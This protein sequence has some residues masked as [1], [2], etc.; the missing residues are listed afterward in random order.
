ME[1]VLKELGNLQKSPDKDA[2][3]DL[4]VA[5]RRCRSVAA[6][7]REVDPAPAWHELRRLP[8]KLFRKL[9]EMRDTQI[10]DQ[11]VKEHGAENDKLRAVLHETFQA[12]EPKLTEEA[13][14][15]AG[16]FDEK[17]WK[18]LESK[19]SKRL[20]LV[21]TGSLAAQ[22]LA[23]ERLNEAKASHGKAL[24]KEKPE[25]WHG[26][27]IGLKK[28]RYT[29]ENLLPQQYE[30]W[31][32]KL[33]ELQDIL[34]EVH[35]LDVLRAIIK[36]KASGEAA[37]ARAEWER[38]IERERDARLHD[39]RE[40][41]IGK[42]SFWQEWAA[43]LP[44]Q[45]RLQLA[46]VARLRA[47]ARATDAHPRR[48]A[49]ISR[50]S[51]ALFDT[52][53]RVHAAPIFNDHEMRRIVRAAARL[54]GMRVK[55]SKGASEK[56][57]RRFLHELPAPPSWTHARW[58]LLAWTVRYNRGLEPKIKENAFA[59]LHQEQQMDIRGLAGVIRVA[60]GLRKCGVR[61]GEGL[62][63]EKT[64]A[65]IVLQIPGLVDSAENAA[66]LAAAKHLL[67]GYLG[68]PLIL[69]PAPQSEKIFALPSLREEP[70]IAAASD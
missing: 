37:G 12:Q 47:T 42:N 13:L 45:E 46:A 57:A 53:G 38:T 70:P 61:N 35:D 67:D 21:P 62:R 30:L 34:G 40:M 32:P 41:S 63:A 9:G 24:R 33:K 43:A 23:V 26:L 39:Y 18:R 49:C 64:S 65:A 3:H 14:R 17:S 28:F 15:L 54:S 44:Q 36:Q 69:K 5:I 25:T 16:K 60:R 22:C 58:E 66:R 31:S 59:R 6:V 50:L 27:R 19:L 55:G 68:K 1:K 11:W 52:L 8:K 7:M 51:M 10:M 20:R 29:V 48:A 2:V 56:A 4:R